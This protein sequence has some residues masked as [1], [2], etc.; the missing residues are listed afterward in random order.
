MEAPSFW[1]KCS[2]CKSPI[3]FNQIFWVCSVSTCRTQKKG[4]AFCKVSC[5][6]AH[7][8]LLRHRE[9]WAEEKRSPTQD[10][11]SKGLKDP[12]QGLNKSA[13]KENLSQAHVSPFSH[14]SKT[15]V[16][17]KS[18][19]QE[20]RTVTKNPQIRKESSQPIFQG[21]LALQPVTEKEILIVASKLKNYIK[22]RSGGMN[23]S[24][25]V[26]EA[27]SDKVRALCDE[28]IQNANQAGRKTVMDR[29]F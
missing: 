13:E 7:L 16:V 1:K 19:G 14:S 29:D 24:A 2:S 23:T 26:M 22:D 4:L 9:S 12:F 8:S 11:F 15:T 6:D 20:K 27:L 17:R 25:S 10:Q 21:G 5:W 28:A 18:G 3:G